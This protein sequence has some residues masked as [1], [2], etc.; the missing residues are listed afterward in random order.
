[1]SAD[2]YEQDYHLTPRGW[3][4]GDSFY[5]GSPQKN[6]PPPTDR[7]LT[8]A[9]RTEQASPFSPSI[10]EWVEKWRSSDKAEV[11]RLVKQF[12]STPK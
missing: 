9:D 2:N 10:H 5:Y 3:E 6:L 8:V 12:G 11:D 7:V 4:V 1:M